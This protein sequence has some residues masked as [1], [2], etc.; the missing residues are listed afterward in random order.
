MVGVT[1]SPLLSG[2]VKSVP[3]GDTLI[4]MKQA[5][6]KTGP[7][8]EMRLSLSS[9]RA[10]LLSRDTQS[11]EPHSFASREALRK[12]L[13]GHTVSF[14]IDYRVTSLSRVFAT[15]YPTAAA[16][17][18]SVNMD[19]VESGHCRVRRP[20]TANEEVSPE[21]DQL[22]TAEERAIS[23]KLGIHGGNSLDDEINSKP[24]NIPYDNNN[25]L[26]LQGE[27]LVKVCDGK[28]FKGVIEYVVT[29]SVVKAF[30]R[31]VPVSNDPNNHEKCDRLL[32]LSLT[33][34][35]CPGF[36][37]TG[38]APSS[39]TSSVGA[40]SSIGA[41]V[42]P[43]NT[44]A[45]SSSTTSP[46]PPNAEQQQQ[47][48]VKAMPF[49][50]NARFLTEIRLL[51][52]D[53]FITI[54]G[55]D[56]NDILLANIEGPTSKMY[57]GEELLRTGMAKTFSWSLDKSSK[58][59]A[60]RSAE[61]F[62]KSKRLGLWKTFQQSSTSVA[63]SDKFVGKVIEV[64]SGDMLSVVDD[65]TGQTKRITLASVRSSRIE[66]GGSARDRSALSIGPA[67]DAKEALRRKIIG[68]RVS[69]KI[70]Y[71]KE[72]GPEAV[73]KDVM[74]FATVCKESINNIKSK[75][76]SLNNDIA[77]GMIAGGLL[78]VVR[79]RGEE[80]RASNYEEYLEKEAIS[81]A[82]KKGMHSTNAI[83][84]TV[85]INNLTGPDAKKRSRDV[86]SGLQRNGPYKGIVEFV[87][88]ASRYRIY[89]PSESMVITLALR[90]VR[91]P[92]GTRRSYGPDGTIREEAAG[93]PH[94]DEALNFMKE[95]V[96]QR[97]VEVE[98]SNVDR[99]G[100]FLGN[101]WLLNAGGSEQKSDIS[102]V[103]LKSGFGY[104][105]ESFDASRDRLG[106]RYSEIEKDS[107]AGM[108]G[109][110]L[111]YV[112]P[113]AK[114][115]DRKDNITGIMNMNL[116]SSSTVT[117]KAL[118]KNIGAGNLLNRFKGRVCEIGFG[119]RIFIHESSRFEKKLAEVAQA[120]SDM[121]LDSIGA[122]PMASLKNGEAI[123]AKFSADGR[124]YRAKILFIHKTNAQVDVRFIDYGNE[125][126]V[127][128]KDVRKLIGNAAS[129]AKSPPAAIEV[130]LAY[131]VIP[132]KDDV[133]GIP[134]GETLRDLVFTGQDV[135][136]LLFHD[137]DPSG[138]K[139]C[140]LCDIL[141]EEDNQV[142]DSKDDDKEKES[143]V[144]KKDS[145]KKFISVR[146]EMLKYGLARI[147]RKKKDRACKEAFKV[148]REYE[149]IGIR[150]RQFLWN[151]GEAF[152]SDCDDETD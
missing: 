144:V 66:K 10:P 150:S 34:I 7:P 81:I 50:A 26:L 140:V 127:D 142:D 33:G 36:K 43:S 17:T 109:V 92:M 139:T 22:I 114:E 151:Y 101:V 78:S 51:H 93:E 61:Q 122:A 103:L 117:S 57:I 12:R 63:N 135:D 1:A 141:I 148:L 54:E 19:M 83:N 96:M 99:V 107:R 88:G 126:L 91:C 100:A 68:K 87:S 134:A 56:R 20:V 31:D 64:I 147:I 115:D 2:I 72:P 69:V 5:A 94:G 131:V 16:S 124:W 97:D 49:A 111:D 149:E 74:V 41:T 47:N 110:W 128:I 15:V 132:G 14:R 37:R 39:T 80:D 77:M 24:R 76:D 104:L 38:P 44:D 13:I 123:V 145:E 152:E 102:E 120:L 6:A 143:D 106:S 23:A 71:T 48:T 129:V 119:G 146:E 4:V 28:V 70:E 30:L 25:N 46:T 105:H 113:S 112:E 8:P 27:D 62:A 137:S 136:V 59:P 29:G 108:R 130:S 116:N 3:S 85:R 52:K 82:T 89:L 65:K 11:D 53:V 90:A 79:H 55:G 84:A 95:R 98:I 73:R 40:A 42:A 21:L 60:L 133:C 121:K 67:A 45:S 9:I 32:T 18:P 125:Q 138:A 86:L 75:E 35:Q 118:K 58:A